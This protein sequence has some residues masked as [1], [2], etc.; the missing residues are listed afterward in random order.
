MKKD[1][2]ML[3]AVSAE[4]E[5]L[6]ACASPTGVRALAAGS[7]RPRRV[8]GARF[9]TLAT[10]HHVIPMVY[11]A[12][13]AA[14][15]NNIDLLPVEFLECLQRDY[16][17]I[18]A[19]N[20]RATAIL[21]RLQSLMESKG[22]RLVPIKGPVLAVLA[23]GSTSLR[24]FEDLDWIVAGEEVLRAVA[25][26]E[27]EGYVAREIPPG[28]NRSRYAASR[29]DWSMHKP[30]KT[31]HVDLKPALISHA[32]A[33]RRATEYMVGACRSIALGDGRACFAPGPEAML[34]AVCMDGANEMWAKLSSVA[35]AAALLSNVAGADWAGLLRD[36]GRLGQKRSLLTGVLV[37]QQV[38][39]CML[40][41]AF[42]KDAEEDPAAGRLAKAAADRMLAERSLRTGAARRAGYALRTRERFRDRVRF[43]SRSLF[44]AGAAD[45]NQISL[46][47][48]WYPLYSCFRPFRLAWDAARG[49]ARR[50]VAAEASSR[51]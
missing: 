17:A 11:R 13:K 42:H 29:Q 16:L 37:A 49:R 15:Q 26:L 43:L 33:D 36:A 50:I 41:E 51:A 6:C 46:P 7:F 19:H 14:A 8:D 48:A 21:H 22:V 44:V 31:P 10:N 18:A 35:D 40:P 34:L 28:A 27:Q 32:L 23:Y 9:R 25:L 39:G 24:Q 38:L 47:D 4:M 30:G 2:A 12:V 5:L 1:A 20:L 3:P 45:L